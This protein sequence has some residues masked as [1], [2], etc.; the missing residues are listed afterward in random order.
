MALVVSGRTL[1]P[2]KVTFVVLAFLAVDFLSASA[3]EPCFFLVEAE[4][5]E[6]KQHNV[7]TINFSWVTGGKI[8]CDTSHTK[9]NYK[10]YG[11]GSNGT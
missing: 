10:L 4:P 3:P 7:I 1:P 8:L 2:Y 5:P 11:P 6:N 9:P